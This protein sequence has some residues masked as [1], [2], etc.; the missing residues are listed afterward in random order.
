M[1]LLFR[2]NRRVDKV[3]QER[4]GIAYGKHR[5]LLCLHIVSL[6]HYFVCVCNSSGQAAQEAVVVRDPPAN[7]RDM[8][9]WF[10]PG[11]GRSPG[12]EHAGILAW[13]IPWTEKP[14]GLEPIWSQR[15]RRE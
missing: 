1:S 4:E 11:L 8:R 6:T 7:A 14:G 10:D 5:L 2:E 15:V 9:P 13:R 12:G 3:D